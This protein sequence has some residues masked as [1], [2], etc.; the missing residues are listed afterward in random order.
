[1][2]IKNITNLLVKHEGFRKLAY[3][4]A[5]GRPLRPGDE[6]QGKVTI[7]IGRNITDKG[8]TQGEAEMLLKS[9]IQ[10][11]TKAA[12]KY[13]W[14]EGLNP[15]R[16]AV[17]VSMIFNMGSI[18]DFRLM[19]QAISFRDWPE[20]VAQMLDSKWATQI[21]SGRLSDLTNMMK[22]GQWPPSK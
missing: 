5:T 3:D 8:L 10:E 16:Q 11:A 15:A 19:R 17:I 20:T 6:L 7:G 14:F 9:D 21:G 22:T 18:D 4:D 13:K 12:K 1:M 2:A